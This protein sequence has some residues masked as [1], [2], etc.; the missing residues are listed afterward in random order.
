MFKFKN[1][2][3]E[4]DHQIRTS[5]ETIL[6]LKFTEESWLQCTLPVKFGGIGIRSCEDL[7]IPAFMSSIFSTT[8]L[9]GY[10]E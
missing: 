6:N 7:T 8:S 3:A 4:M 9:I 5:L 1:L 10:P 2:L